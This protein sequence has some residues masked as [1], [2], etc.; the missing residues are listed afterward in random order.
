[1]CFIEPG[2]RKMNSVVNQQFNPG[3]G[4]HVTPSKGYVKAYN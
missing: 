2:D 4:Y 1:M 3:R